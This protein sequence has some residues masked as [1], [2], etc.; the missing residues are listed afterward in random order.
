[1]LHAS[2]HAWES[3]AGTPGPWDEV[4]ILGGGGKCVP[5]VGP[6]GVLPGETSAG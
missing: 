4:E 5:R 2:P 6:P 1:M 3:S